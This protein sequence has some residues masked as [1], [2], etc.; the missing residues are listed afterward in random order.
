M[1]TAGLPGYF[2]GKVQEEDGIYYAVDRGDGGRFC[3]WLS[4]PVFL[5]FFFFILMSHCSCFSKVS[6]HFSPFYEATAVYET[7]SEAYLGVKVITSIGSIYWIP[8]VCQVFQIYY[9]I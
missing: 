9:L 2:L 1:S 8:A 7:H 4:F 5:V 6:V 3:S